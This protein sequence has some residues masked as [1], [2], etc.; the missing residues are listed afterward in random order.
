MNTRKTIKSPHVRTK[1]TNTQLDINSGR[2]QAEAV[3]DWMEGHRGAFF[4]ILNTLQHKPVV[5]RPRDYFASELS[6]RHLANDKPFSFNN[7][8]WPGIARYLVLVDPSLKSKLR[9]RDSAID[10]WGLYPVSYLK[11]LI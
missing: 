3:K 9:M 4:F 5:V 8:Y 10:V 2:K 7:N 11:E 1:K 6:R